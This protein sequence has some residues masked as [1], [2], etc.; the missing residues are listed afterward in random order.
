[1]VGGI[2]LSSRRWRQRAAD[3]GRPAQVAFALMALY[4]FLNL[5][6]S[7]WVERTTA[8]LL[9]QQRFEPTLVVASP[10]PLLFWR[11]TVAW[12]TA[13]RWGRGDYDPINGLRVDLS[14]QPLDLDDPLLAQAK[15]DSPRVRGFLSWSRM[16][17]VINQGG[18]RFL[19]DQ[20]YYDPVAVRAMPG[21]LQGLAG[22]HPFLVPLA[23]DRAAGE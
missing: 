16:P 13:D 14:S 7:A 11:R 22:R 18:A 20:R 5:A 12:R 1:M 3:P 23:K 15:I 6:E 8:A 9:R 2:A 10:P 19:T 4:I 21:W 17:M